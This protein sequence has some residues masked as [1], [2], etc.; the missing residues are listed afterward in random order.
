MKLNPLTIQ[1]L[2]VKITWQ[3]SEFFPPLL[4]LSQD[5]SKL[6]RF[7]FRIFRWNDGSNSGSPTTTTESTTSE[8]DTDSAPPLEPFLLAGDPDLEEETSLDPQTP[9]SLYLRPYSR[10]HLADKWQIL[11]VP[12]LVV[13]HLESQKILSYHARFELLKESKLEQTFQTWSKGEKITFGVKDFLYALRWTIFFGLVSL[14]YL[15]AVNKGWCP[16]YVA[17]WSSSLSQSLGGENPIQ[18]GGGGKIEL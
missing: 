9:I 16:N 15:F 7:V 18:A 12:N 3:W 6:T 5:E 13:Y 14:V 1:T 17:L 10:V 11:G 4:S 8:E 2:K